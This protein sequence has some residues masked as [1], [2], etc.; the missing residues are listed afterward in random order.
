MYLFNK[1]KSKNKNNLISKQTLG[2]TRNKTYMF[3]KIRNP[4][5]DK[6]SI[7]KARIR[8]RFDKLLE[9]YKSKSILKLSLFQTDYEKEIV[10]W[11]VNDKYCKYC[12]NKKSHIC[13]ICGEPICKKCTKEIPLKD[14]KPNL[15]F[16]LILCKG[17][18]FTEILNYQNL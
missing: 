9:M 8:C 2:V 11:N 17:L 12:F 16:G 5:N 4:K 15:F 3:N 10:Y 18:C 14:F 1:N 7:E 6:L 13:R